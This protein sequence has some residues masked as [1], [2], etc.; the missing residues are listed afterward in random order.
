[1]QAVICPSFFSFKLILNVVS[2]TNGL[3]SRVSGWWRTS[4]IGKPRPGILVQPPTLT[5]PATLHYGKLRGTRQTFNLEA[6]IVC[7]GFGT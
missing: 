3:S 4:L 6:N 7:G 1:M 5:T 2:V